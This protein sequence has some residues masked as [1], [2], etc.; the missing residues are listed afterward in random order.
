MIPWRKKK[1]I[2]PLLFPSVVS[3]GCIGSIL[4]MSVC[5]PEEDLSEPSNQ[6]RDSKKMAKSAET[7]HKNSL[8]DRA[9]YKR[10]AEIQERATQSIS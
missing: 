6:G 9:P 3:L 10:S 7:A 5:L 4:P 1:Q 8:S 2:F